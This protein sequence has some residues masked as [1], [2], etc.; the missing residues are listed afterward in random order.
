MEKF[1]WVSAQHFE[2]LWGTQTGRSTLVRAFKEEVEKCYSAKSVTVTRYW[3]AVHALC[4]EPSL[5]GWMRM[6]LLACFRGTTLR[7]WLASCRR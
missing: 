7:K 5:A 3:C 2:K 6:R 1:Q 4:Y